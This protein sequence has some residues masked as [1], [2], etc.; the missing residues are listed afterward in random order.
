[1]DLARVGAQQDRPVEL[2]DRRHDLGAEI[3]RV[4][5]TNANLRPVGMNLDQR[6]AAQL[7]RLQK[8]WVVRA[9]PGQQRRLYIGDFHMRL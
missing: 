4:R 3:A 1:M 7:A 2:D 8:V 5:L 6:G 9:R